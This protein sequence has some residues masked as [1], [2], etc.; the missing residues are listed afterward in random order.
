MNNT[1]IKTIL[2]CSLFMVSTLISHMSY[3]HIYSGNMFDIFGGGARQN[4]LLRHTCSAPTAR[5]YV[6]VS[7]DAINK[8]IMS[9]TVFKDDKAVTVS[10]L[11]QQAND[12]GPSIRLHAGAGNYYIIA[13]QTA[14]TG[15]ISAIYRIQYHCEDA[16]G[17]EVESGLAEVIQP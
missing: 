16:G 1:F 17:S 2:S 5:L 10:D 4:T 9:V 11:E 14:L 3:A 7:D 8:G 15:N 12:Y 6:E 13:S